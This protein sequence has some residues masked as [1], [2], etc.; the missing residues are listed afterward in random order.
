MTGKV[1]GR[2]MVL[3]KEENKGNKRMWL[4]KCE[5]G[6]TKIVPAVNLLGGKTF[7]CGCFQRE[8]ASK[9][10]K[11]HGE[12]KGERLYSIWKNM[13]SRCYCHNKPDYHRYGGRGIEVC[14]EWK[15]DYSAF[16]KWALANGYDENLSIDRIDFN[17]I[18]SR[19]IVA[20]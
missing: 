18:M 20:G 4:C 11:I 8:Q 10:H 15:E 6:N 2:L 17:K 5:C 9:A 14:K 1:F 19:L 16:R 7:S 12:A 13:K 3:K